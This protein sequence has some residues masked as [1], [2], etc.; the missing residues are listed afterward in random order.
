MTRRLG[1]EWTAHD[2]GHGF[3]I[4]GI[5]EEMMRMLS[6]RQESIT[7]DLRV[8]A[9]R[10][11]QRY[12][13]KPSQRE[14]ARLAQASNL[15]TRASKGGALDFALVHAGWADKLTATPAR[16][17]CSSTAGSRCRS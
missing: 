9:A 7:A 15:K 3:E 11:E 8:R 17:R 1:I 13:R 2:D 14:L 5:S 10:F 4:R 16:S 12:G 6:S